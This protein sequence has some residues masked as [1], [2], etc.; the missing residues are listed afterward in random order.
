MK[1]NLNNIQEVKQSLKSGNENVMSCIFEA[2]HHEL[3][4]YA[5]HFTGDYDASK[6]IV[7][8]VFL[9]LWKRREK[10]EDINSIKNFLYR[11]VYNGFLNHYRKNSKLTRFEYYQAKFID[12]MLMPENEQ[13]LKVHI[14]IVRREIEKLPTKCKQI[15]ILSKQEGLTN[16]EIANFLNISNK[17]VENQMTKAFKILREK[18]ENK[19]GFI[20]FLVLSNFTQVVSK[21]FE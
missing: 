6:D 10:L 8:D 9:N 1:I 16:I 5:Y 21:R 4:L 20:Y 15:F 12:E 19:V 11:A 17:T 14:D 7:Q 2:Y 13:E 3:C 18:L